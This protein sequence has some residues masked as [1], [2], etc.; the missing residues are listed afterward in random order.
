MY[1]SQGTGKALNMHAKPSESR[2]EGQIPWNWYY[3]HNFESLFG[4]QESN[5]GP[6]RQEVSVPVIEPSFQPLES[7]I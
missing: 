1:K 5:M 2:K 3:R 4:G 6:S 7:V